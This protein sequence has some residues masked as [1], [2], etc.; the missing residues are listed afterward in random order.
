MQT[1]GFYL[2]ATISPNKVCVR[3]CSFH[4]NI[5]RE[6]IR[7]LNNLGCNINFGQI[8]SQ[9][10]SKI[11]NA[12]NLIVCTA[13]D[14]YFQLTP[15]SQIYK[16][17]VN[18]VTL[19]LPSKQRHD[20]TTIKNECL[21]QLLT[22]WRKD[23]PSLKYCWRAEKQANGN[24]H[25]HILS[26]TF[27]HYKHL[28]SDWNRIINKL[29]YVDSYSKSFEGISFKSYLSKSMSK[30]WDVKVLFD[31]WKKGTSEGW[32]NPNTTD[33]HAV[34][35]IKDVASY[36]AKYCAKK[37]PGAFI[38]DP[39]YVKSG[40][41]KRL[42]LSLKIADIIEVRKNCNIIRG[43]VW[44]CDTATGRFQNVSITQFDDDFEST[45]SVLTQAARFA[46]TKEYISV[47]YGTF[48]PII[49]NGASDSLFLFQLQISKY[50][51]SS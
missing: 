1:D 7:S 47:Y 18:F 6:S 15:L 9:T 25:F 35:R 37:S 16:F 45:L 2:S 10:Q 29:G 32:K 13:D 38:P 8:S 14:K 17:K 22:E 42:K 19:T 28:R 41:S 39:Q 34:R 5:R 3:P 40:I 46:V 23:N 50:V 44:G 49:M 20:D 31:R 43:K 27:Y 26:N 48:Y 30:G 24:I 33:V 11:I 51:N 36:V 4:P 12:I 21:N